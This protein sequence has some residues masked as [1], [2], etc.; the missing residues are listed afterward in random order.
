[1]W[2]RLAHPSR[3]QTGPSISAVA[4]LPHRCTSSSDLAH[5]HDRRDAPWPATSEDTTSASRCRTGRRT[6]GTDPLGGERACQTAAGISPASR[7]CIPATGTGWFEFATHE[8]VSVRPQIGVGV[9]VAKLAAQTDA[10]VRA[11]SHSPDSPTDTTMPTAHPDDLGPWSEPDRL[12]QR[13]R[14]NEPCGRPR[15]CRSLVILGRDAYPLTGHGGMAAVSQHPRVRPHRATRSQ[16][17]SSCRESSRTT[18]A[19]TITP[20][21]V[22]R[23]FGYHP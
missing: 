16:L 17:P 23:H 21:P 4:P 11:L 3:D 15:R 5:L 6:V 19:R 8:G 18:S 1:V 12:C 22:T 2:R 13:S 9:S 20:D 7:L 14:R 10:G